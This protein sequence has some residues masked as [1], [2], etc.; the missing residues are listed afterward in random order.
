VPEQIDHPLP[1]QIDHPLRTIFSLLE[2][3]QL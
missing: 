2:G 1:I 3:R